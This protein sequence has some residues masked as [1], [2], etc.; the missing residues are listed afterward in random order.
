MTK[1]NRI[2]KDLTTKNVIVAAII[3]TAMKHN[4][5]TNANANVA[6]T[7]ATAMLNQKAIVAINP[8]KSLKYSYLL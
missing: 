1:T 2:K 4:Q 8:L 7:I 5:K 6:V 3:A